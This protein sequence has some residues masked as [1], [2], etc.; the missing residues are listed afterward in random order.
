L[1]LFFHDRSAYS[2]Q[3][4]LCG[5]RII[6]NSCYFQ[7]AWSIFLA[8]KFLRSKGSHCDL[9][10]LLLLLLFTHN[11]CIWIKLPFDGNLRA[12]FLRV[13]LASLHFNSCVR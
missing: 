4:C 10:R 7:C 3:L 2:T 8:D 5:R 9:S 6:S 11:C 1:W 13:Y 12:C